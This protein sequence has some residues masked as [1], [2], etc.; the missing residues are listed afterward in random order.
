MHVVEVLEKGIA[1]GTQIG[2]QIYVSRDG[3]PIVDIALG[4][5]RPGVPMATDSLMVWFSM[6]KAVTSVAVAQQWERGALDPDDL[7]VQLRPRV[8][9]AGKGRHHAPSSPH[10]HG[11]H[12]ER[13]RD[14]AGPALARVPRRQP[15]PHLR[16]TDRAGLGAREE[17]GLP[18]R[19]RHVGARRDR[20]AHE[21]PAV[22]RVRAR[23]DLR[24]ARHA[25]Q[26]GRDA[27]GSLRGVRRPHRR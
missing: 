20:R 19:G 25:R 5:A 24:A 2:A 14:P 4:D 6:T 26:L 1:D 17:G 10:A 3:S 22:R 7:V 9:R 8:R 27:G 12:P 18:R 21:R 16:R 15:G 13:R 11:R 23:G